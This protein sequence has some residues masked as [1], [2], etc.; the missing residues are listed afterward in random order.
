LYGGQIFAADHAEAPLVESDQASDIADVYAFL[1]PNDNAKVIL[2]F[3]VHGFIVPGE[4][5][6][7][8]AFDHDVR[9]RFNIENTG[10]ARPDKIFVVTFS[11]QTSRSQPQ[12]ATITMFGKKKSDTISFTAPTTVSSSTASTAPAPVVTT[13]SASEISFFAGLTDDPFFFDIPGFNRFTASVLGGTPDLSLLSRGRNTFAGY[14]VQMIALSVPAFLLQGPADSIIGV[15]ATT[16]R[17]RNVH[18]SNDRDPLVSG[19]PAPIDRM[20]VPAIN[21]VLIPFAR[22]NEYNRATTADD[23]AGTFATDIINTLTSLGTDSTHIGILAGVAVTGG[24]QLRLDTS[25][26][27]TGTQG[28]LDPV[29]GFPNGRRP[30]DDVI[31]TILFL[32]TNEA[33]TTGDNV[34]ANDVPFR[35][36]FPFFAASQQP[37]PSGTLDDNTRN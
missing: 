15:S 10:D 19:L 2:A 6:N 17:Q 35:D 12:T 33:L 31:D 28:G 5:G 29:A 27:N 18:Y 8:G 4:N 34:N 22:K 24:D 32:V 26:P 21:T 11:A 13:D 25:I 37:F 7:L 14:N 23:A 30:A 3:D 9:Y 16:L 36:T 20:G 1:D